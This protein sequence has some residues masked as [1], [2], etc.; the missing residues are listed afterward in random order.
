M[1]EIKCLVC[2]AEVTL[3]QYMEDIAYQ[4]HVRCLE[5]N[6]TFYVSIDRSGELLEF[7]QEESRQGEDA[8]VI[9]L[10]QEEYQQMLS[11]PEQFAQKI[12]ERMKEDQTK[13]DNQS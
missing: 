13:S 10:T 2:E 8:G 3:P 5:C 7:K 12:F 9:K 1:K 4:G 6:T 11:N